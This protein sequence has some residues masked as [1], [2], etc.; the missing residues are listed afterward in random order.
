MALWRKRSSAQA[1]RE[2]PQSTVGRRHA[3]HAAL[4]AVAGAVGAGL[5]RGAD[6]VRGADGDTITV[7]GVFTGTSV[8]LIHNTTASNT[9]WSAL[10][11]AGIGMQGGGG[12]GWGVWGYSG[13]SGGSVT[14]GSTLLGVLGSSGDPGGV[15]VNGYSGGAGGF[16]VWSQGATGVYGETHTAS[17]GLG[18]K[19]VNNLGGTAVLGQSSGGSGNTNVGVYGQS[20]NGTGGIG[21]LGLCSNDINSVGVY[22]QSATGKGFLGFSNATA[23]VGATGVNSTSGIGLYGVSNGGFGAVISGNLWVSGSQTVLGPKSA[24]VRDTGGKLRRMYSLES[25]ESWFEDFGSGQLSG[26]SATVQLEPGFAGVVHGDGYRVFTMPKGDC[27]GLYVTTLTSGGFTVH[28][29][30]GGTSN[31]AFDYRVVAKRKDIAGA[32]LEH[33]DEPALPDVPSE[34]IT[35]EPAPEPIQKHRIG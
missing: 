21:V 8:T 12:G 24:A 26:G 6:P 31:V 7:G 1:V 2:Q 15:G 29:L 22:A 16:G 10:A 28:E 34:P 11:F 13:S 23:G 33:V 30:Q 35:P 3:L 32:R 9:A 18:V 17:A 14:I 4:A 25:P 19:G 27:K 20:A 5:L